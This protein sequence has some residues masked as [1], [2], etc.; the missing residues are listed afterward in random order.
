MSALKPITDDRLVDLLTARATEGLDAQE[1]A[2]L[3]AALARLDDDADVDGLELAAAA[4]DVALLGQAGAVEPVPTD[5]MAGLLAAAPAVDTG[6]RATAVD[7]DDPPRTTLKLDPDAAGSPTVPAMTPVHWSSRIGW[8]AAA[9]AIVIA[10]IAWFTRPEPTTQTVVVEK[11]VPA[12]PGAEPTAAEKRAALLA[13][14]DDAVTAQWTITEGE[15]YAGVTGDVVWSDAKQ[16]GYMR[17]AGMP[18]NNPSELQYQL[19]IVDPDVQGPIPVYDQVPPVDGGVFDVTESG[20][21]IVPI[22]AK[23]AVTNPAAFA[24]TAEKPGGVVVS[25]GPLRVVAAVGA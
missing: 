6:N 7:P 4:A 10:A 19:W 18:V 13:E 20:E 8:L 1:A 23:I 25:K 12:Q 5:L 22:D 3:E 16:E 24:I 11:P 2:E 15:A 21:V 9:A 14:A 17:L